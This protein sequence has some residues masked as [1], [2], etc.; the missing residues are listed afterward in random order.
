MT[1]GARE[2]YELLMCSVGGGGNANHLNT[3]DDWKRGGATWGQHNA[4]I[5]TRCK[6]G[7]ERIQ[8]GDQGGQSPGRTRQR[9]TLVPVVI[10]MT[11]AR[12][13]AG[14][15]LKVQGG[16]RSGQVYQTL[17]RSRVSKIV[18]NFTILG[19]GTA[20]LGDPWGAEDGRQDLDLS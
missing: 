15:V 11:R 7:R 20:R 3:P 6:G 4:R 12:E 9:M 10:A 2:N 13:E 16:S 14:S 1:T 8:G 19:L 18:G 5:L 17:S